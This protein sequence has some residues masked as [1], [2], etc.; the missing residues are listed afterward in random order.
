MKQKMVRE[1]QNGQVYEYMPL[2][3]YIVSAPG[4]CRGRPTFKHTRIEVA[5][6]LERL[7]GGETIDEIVAGFHGRFSRAALE[8]GIK[9]AAKALVHEAGKRALVR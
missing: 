6:I 7:S 3:K 2:G 5:G 4:V 1:K 9:L 8:E